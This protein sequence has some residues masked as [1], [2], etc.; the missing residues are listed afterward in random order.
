MLYWRRPPRFWI[1]TA[2]VLLLVI[3]LIEER[4]FSKMSNIVASHYNLAVHVRMTVE[5]STRDKKEFK[6]AVATVIDKPDQLEDYRLAHDSVKCYCDHH[7]Y[8]FHLLDLKSNETLA[9]ACPQEDFMFRRH[10]VV[11]H[12]L[13]RHQQDIE[14][15]L[16][17]DADM[18]V[19]NPNHLIEEFVNESVEMIFYERSFNF[20]IA[21]GSYIARNS[22]YTRSFL[23]DWANY[24][25]KIAHYK[26]AQ[27]FYGTDNG[28]IHSLFLDKFCAG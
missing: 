10:C 11:A 16:F 23:M 17:L 20:E 1:I 15:L 9:S 18:G 27:G 13:E 3:V 5:R 19:V 8:P 12:F 14:W 25:Y 4:W 24:Y 28:A 6:I 21:A 26:I 2:T 7:Q 22:V